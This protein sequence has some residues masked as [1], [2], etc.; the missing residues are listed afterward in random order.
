ML[1]TM[2][3]ISLNIK[4]GM[5]DSRAIGVCHSREFEENKT[6]VFTV[7]VFL[8]YGFFYLPLVYAG[9]GEATEWSLQSLRLSEIIID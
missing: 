7:R 1:A 4:D 9:R 6:G 8:K 2:G 5:V 3:R